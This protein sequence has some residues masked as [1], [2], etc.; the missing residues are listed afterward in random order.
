MVL[1]ALRNVKP[2]GNIVDELTLGHNSVALA[3]ERWKALDAEK[4]IREVEEETTRV[5]EET[6]K[7]IQVL[8]EKVEITERNY[9]MTLKEMPS[10]VS[11]IINAFAIALFPLFVITK[12]NY[13]LHDI[14]S[15]FG[16]EILFNDRPVKI[17]IW[18]GFAAPFLYLSVRN[19]VYV[20]RRIKVDPRVKRFEYRVL[21]RQMPPN[22]LHV[23]SS[24]RARNGSQMAEPQREE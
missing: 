3:L 1:R 11:N 13:L 19:L 21:H 17:A 16:A 8:V 5:I 24:I 7:E 20:I 2:G 22:S 10:I 14:F 6:K 18:S 4:R 12:G 23:K 15:Y 9:S